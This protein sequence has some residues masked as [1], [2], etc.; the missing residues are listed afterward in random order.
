MA[1]WYNV[2]CLQMISVI[3]ETKWKLNK[4]KAVILIVKHVITQLALRSVVIIVATI[5]PTIIATLWLQCYYPVTYEL[6]V[7]T[8][9]CIFLIAI[10]QGE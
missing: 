3:G 9:D 6:L 4:P 2:Q 1:N 7:N 5:K 10:T 8:T